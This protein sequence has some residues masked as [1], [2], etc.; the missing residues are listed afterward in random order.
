MLIWMNFTFIEA[1]ANNKLI[2][3]EG[4]GLVFLFFE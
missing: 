1:R 3:Y 2:G 4:R